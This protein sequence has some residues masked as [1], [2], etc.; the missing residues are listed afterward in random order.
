MNKENFMEN[1]DHLI[2]ELTQKMSEQFSNSL[3]E[4]SEFKEE[5]Y[6]GPLLNM[7]L[8]VYIGS[9][10][11]ILDVIKKTTIGEVKLINNIDLTKNSLMKTITDLPFIKSVEI[12]KKD[13]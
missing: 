7:I 9:L 11:Q 13:N 6:S 8:S 10:M 1:Y 3:Y 5:F 12:F 2:P 4:Y